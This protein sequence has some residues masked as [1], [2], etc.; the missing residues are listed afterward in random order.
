M[1]IIFPDESK[2]AIE[3]LIVFKKELTELLYKDSY[4]LKDLNKIKE[5]IQR[6]E[7]YLLMADKKK[8]FKYFDSFYELNLLNILNSYLDKGIQQIS[9]FILECI[10]IL[11][12]NIQNSGLIFYIYSTKYPTYIHGEHLN[13]IDKVISIDARKKEEFL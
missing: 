9:F 11:L 10:S 1:S 5:I 12:T 13:I 6:L 8:L 7:G 2:M 4:D 3:D